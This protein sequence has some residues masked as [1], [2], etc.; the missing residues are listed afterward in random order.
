MKYATW[1]Q[2]GL[3]ST[4]LDP[5]L[6]VS[7]HSRARL[8]QVS[9]IDSAESLRVW[10]RLHSTRL[11]RGSVHAFTRAAI[12]SKPNSLYRVFTRLDWT[13]YTPSDVTGGPQTR[14][15]GDW[16][17]NMPCTVFYISSSVITILPEHIKCWNNSCNAAQNYTSF[18]LLASQLSFYS[19]I[20]GF[21][22]YRNEIPCTVH[23]CV[24]RFP[25]PKDCLH[26]TFVRQFLR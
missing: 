19:L 20:L 5:T 12:T 2:V 14:S 22:L 23:P 4:R 10:T 13:G 8:M 25:A 21:V 1:K 3:D 9:Q 11:D 24:S 16:E 15:E 6:P 18:H 7:K 26:L 17:E